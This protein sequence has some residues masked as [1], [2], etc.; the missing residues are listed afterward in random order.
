LDTPVSLTGPP[1]ETISRGAP[2]FTQR[3]LVTEQLEAVNTTKIE[4]RMFLFLFG[5]SG[6]EAGKNLTLFKFLRT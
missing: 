1:N 3:A 4:G 5:R 6:E 2:H